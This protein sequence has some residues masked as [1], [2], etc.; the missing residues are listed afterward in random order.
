MIDKTLSMVFMLW[1][2]IKPGLLWGVV[3]LR[4]F[5]I[6]SNIVIFVNTYISLPKTN[7]AR[8]L[9]I[10]A[11][12]SNRNTNDKLIKIIQTT[13]MKKGR[14]RVAKIKHHLSRENKAQENKLLIYPDILR[15]R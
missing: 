8:I 7:F 11:N 9:H 15:Y 5:S 2:S 1:Q 13:S 6:C 3:V 14:A 4:I 12:P 10:S